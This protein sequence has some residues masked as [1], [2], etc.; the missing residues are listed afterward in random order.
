MVWTRECEALSL[1][2]FPQDFWLFRA[3]VFSV[4]NTILAVQGVCV[5]VC[6]QWKIPLCVYVFSHTSCLISCSSVKNTI[7]ILIRIELICRVPWVVCSCFNKSFQSVNTVC[8][9]I[10]LYH[11]QFLLLMSCSFSVQVFNLLSYLSL[12]YFIPFDAV[13][14][15]IVS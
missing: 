11:L 7:T 15:G 10:Y 6:S 5:C 9:S 4:K 12:K 2:V 1:L 13:L 8:L 14:N 3:R